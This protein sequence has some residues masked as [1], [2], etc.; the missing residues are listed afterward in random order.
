MA[1][2]SVNCIS[3]CICPL[4]STVEMLA[5]FFLED[6]Q[7]ANVIISY[8]SCTNNYTLHTYRPH[9]NEMHS[10]VMCKMHRQ[11]CYNPYQTRFRTN[12]I[13]IS[14]AKAV[15]ISSILEY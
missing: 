11:H 7:S 10:Y 12:Q 15:T 9:L 8:N 6:M 4:I 14:P 5:Y 3:A 1:E 2:W 13:R